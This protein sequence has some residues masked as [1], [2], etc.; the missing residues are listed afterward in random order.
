MSVTPD[1][2]LL[3]GFATAGSA[4]AAAPA[5][6]ARRSAD[7]QAAQSDYLAASA[8]A[9]PDGAGAANR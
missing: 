5:V 4:I 3:P 2:V 9:P 1:A 8:L 7:T 6:T